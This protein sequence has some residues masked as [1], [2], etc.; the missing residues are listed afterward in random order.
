[1]CILCAYTLWYLEVVG[2]ILVLDRMGVFF[3]SEGSFANVLQKEENELTI[4]P[5]IDIFVIV[6]RKFVLRSSA[7]HMAAI[8]IDNT[9]VMVPCMMAKTAAA[10]HH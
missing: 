8:W 6:S 1:M 2:T 3:L 7:T 5:N 10:D 9:I 4:V